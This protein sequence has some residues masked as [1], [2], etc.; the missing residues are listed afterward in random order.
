[1]RIWLLVPIDPS[2][3]VRRAST[4]KDVFVVRAESAD[5]ARRLATA[6]FAKAQAK[7]F[8]GD[9]IAFSPWQHTDKVSVEEVTESDFSE[10]GPEEVLIP[11]AD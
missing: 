8:P 1:M 3:G 5:R 4:Q 11:A 2:D 7:L 9:L 6:M 10:E